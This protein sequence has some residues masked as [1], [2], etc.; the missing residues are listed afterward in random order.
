MA[1]S[2]HPVLLAAKII[3]EKGFKAEVA[4]IVPANAADFFKKLRRDALIL[5]VPIQHVDYDNRYNFLSPDDV[6]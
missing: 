6:L 1:S 2:D 5:L 4:K 3:A